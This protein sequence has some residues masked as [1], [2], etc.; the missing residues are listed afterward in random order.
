MEKGLAALKRL[1]EARKSRTQSDNIAGD[2]EDASAAQTEGEREV[3]SEAKGQSR[4]GEAKTSERRLQFEP[5]VC[6]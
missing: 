3:A 6:A 1:A 5:A 4:E 2:T